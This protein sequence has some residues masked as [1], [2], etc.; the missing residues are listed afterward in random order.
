[1]AYGSDEQGPD[2]V[3]VAPF[4]GSGSSCKVSTAG[5][6][7]PRWSEQGELFYLQGGDVFVVNTANLNPCRPNPRL[8]FEGVE[9]FLWDVS[10]AGDFV[11]TVEKRPTPRLRLIQNWFEELRERVGN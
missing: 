7:S 2:E 1:V 9:E 11:V 5:G 3:W 4:S 6:A 8:A 10:R